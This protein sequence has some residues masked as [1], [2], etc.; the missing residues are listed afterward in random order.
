MYNSLHGIIVHLF[1]DQKLW[2]NITRYYMVSETDHILSNISSE[3]D[4][5]I[6][7]KTAKE[8]RL[9]FNFWFK[10]LHSKD[11][12]FFFQC[13]FSAEREN[14][15]FLFFSQQTTLY[16]LIIW[17][18]QGYLVGYKLLD[19]KQRRD[20][21]RWILD[22]YFDVVTEFSHKNLIFKQFCLFCWNTE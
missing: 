1:D 4:E 11:F 16:I 12:A 6:N 18:N 7:I 8:P 3:A 21:T 14:K 9:F 13:K 17:R 5:F 2:N 19:T 15:R 20:G 10:S 22:Y